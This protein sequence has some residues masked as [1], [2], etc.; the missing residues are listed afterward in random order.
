MVVINELMLF[1]YFKKKK[2]KLRSGTDA[3]IQ[4]E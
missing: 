3:W 4:Q 1:T 2:K